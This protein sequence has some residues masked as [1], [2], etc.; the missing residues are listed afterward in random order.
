MQ[1]ARKLPMG[2]LYKTLVQPVSPQNSTS[3]LYS[4]WLKY[5]EIA[6]GPL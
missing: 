6:N 3:Y 1:N 5:H 2:V 4:I